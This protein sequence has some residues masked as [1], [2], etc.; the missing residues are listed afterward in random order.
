MESELAKDQ[1]FIYPTSVL[2]RKEFCVSYQVL[3]KDLN[4]PRIKR[5]KLLDF[6]KKLLPLDANIPPSYRYVVKS[7][8]KGRFKDNVFKICS[9]CYKRYNGELCICNNIKKQKTIDVALFN[10]EQKIKL[11]FEKY[12]T[13]IQDYKSKTI[14]LNTLSLYL[15][16]HAKN[17]I[18]SILKL[19]F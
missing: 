12:F 11:L 6:I 14:T 13:E 16:A 10:H 3:C 4:L 9:S 15:L 19:K 7:I 8:Y 1:N 2:T 17:R 18:H 5:T